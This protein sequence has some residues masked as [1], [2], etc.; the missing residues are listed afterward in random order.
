MSLNDF[1]ELE[2]PLKP[3]KVRFALYVNAEVVRDFKNYCISKDK[4]MS[5]VVERLM[6]RFNEEAEQSNAGGI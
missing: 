1:E 5:R 6:R 2:D 4:P 3:H